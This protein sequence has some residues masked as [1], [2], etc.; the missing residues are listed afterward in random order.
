M[1]HFGAREISDRSVQASV[2]NWFMDGLRDILESRVRLDFVAK[3]GHFPMVDAYLLHCSPRSGFTARAS[4]VEQEASLA[5]DLHIPGL[6]GENP[7]T[8]G[9]RRSP[10]RKDFAMRAKTSKETSDREKVSRFV[11]AA[12]FQQSK[13]IST[14]LLAL[15]QPHLQE[16][17]PEPDFFGTFNALSRG[18]ESTIRKVVRADTV[19][20]VAN[21]A[22]GAARQSRTDRTFE[23]SRLI[24]GLRQACSAL[25][26]NLPVQQL[27]FDQRTAQDPVPLLMQAD[28]IVQ[29]LRNGPTSGVEYLFD[30]DDF[31]PSKYADQVEQRAARLRQALDTV[32]DA[33][34]EVEAVTLDKQSVTAEYDA[35]FLQSARTFESYCRMAGKTGL[36]DRLRPSETRGGQTE[37]EPP[38]EE[39][40]SSEPESAPETSDR[41]AEEGSA[42]V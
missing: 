18:L 3:V 25:F 5:I 40:E 29:E 24:V 38:P 36:A 22:L 10:P 33:T 27:G 8:G 30:N 4:N 9:F 13:E 7:V 11:L 28:R 31:D 23:L 42:N 14:I 37:I 20:F 41:E 19:L 26:V 21:A 1:G 12:F 32:A 15:F 34:R 6:P 16:G 35:L 17:D 2:N 39:E